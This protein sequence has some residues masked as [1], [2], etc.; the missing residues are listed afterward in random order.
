MTA[1]LPDDAASRADYPLDDGLVGYFPAALAYVARVSKVGNDQHNPGQP[2]HW[3]RSK[4]TDHGN[5]L[6]RHHFDAGKIDPGDNLRHSGKRAWRALADL[7]EELEREEGAP[8]PRNAR[9]A[10]QQLNLPRTD[11]GD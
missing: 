3:D 8:I 7:Q 1:N 4:S 5:K 9:P 11:T 2:M 6:L 10:K